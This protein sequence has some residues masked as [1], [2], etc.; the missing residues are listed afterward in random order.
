M[1]QKGCTSGSHLWVKPKENSVDK[2]GA[3][4]V[5]CREDWHQTGSQVIVVIYAKKFDPTRSEVKVNGVKLNIELYFP[6]EGGFFREEWIL[7]GVSLV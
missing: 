6:E 2:S 1:Q 7:A 4:V 5:K 3:K